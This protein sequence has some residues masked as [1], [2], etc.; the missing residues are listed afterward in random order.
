MRGKVPRSREWILSSEVKVLQLHNCDVCTVATPAYADAKVPGGPWGY[1]C[2]VHF[3]QF[4]C[5]LGTGKGQKLV[6]DEGKE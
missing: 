1:L 6:L 5:E 4:G 3:R 2:A